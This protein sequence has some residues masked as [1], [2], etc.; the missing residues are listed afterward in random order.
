MILLVPVT[1]DLSV[2]DS[3]VIDLAVDQKTIKTM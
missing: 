2:G 1:E 3:F